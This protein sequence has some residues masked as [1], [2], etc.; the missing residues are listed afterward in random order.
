MPRSSPLLSLLLL[1][2][3]PLVPGLGL[4]GAGGRHPECGP[5]LPERCP[6]PV[7]CPAPGIAAHDECGCCTRCLGSEGANCGGPAGARCGPGLV[8]ASRA[9]GAAPEGTGL[10]VCAQRGAVC[11]SDGRTYP[12]VCALRLHA[13]H[14]PRVHPGHLH[15]ARDGPCQF[16][17]VVVLPPRSVHNVTG[18]QVYLSCEVRAVPTAVIT[19]RKVTHSP[20]GIEVLEELPGDHINIAVQISPLRKEDEGVYQCHAAN[21]VGE[22]LSHGTVMVLDLSRYKSPRSLAPAD[23]L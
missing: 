4:H 6:A 10:C 17:P 8:C 13:W 9:E 22:A 3:P 15:K 12:S 18:A 7:R 1:L 11:G 21:V 2:L 19:W 20:E 5:C 14:A 23:R 16:A